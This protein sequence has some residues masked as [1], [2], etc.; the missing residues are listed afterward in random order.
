MLS[1]TIKLLFLL[2]ILIG[3]A[4]LLNIRQIDMS[5]KGSTARGELEISQSH[6]P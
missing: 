3:L 2:A 4:W 1:Y 5:E 6:V